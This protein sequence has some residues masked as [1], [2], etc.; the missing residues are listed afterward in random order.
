MINIIATS[1]TAVLLKK[2]KNEKSST[3]P[4]ERIRKSDD[5]NDDEFS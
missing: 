1:I 4:E 5:S 2:L 3:I